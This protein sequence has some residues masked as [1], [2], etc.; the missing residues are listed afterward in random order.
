MVTQAYLEDA[1]E[2][3]LDGI[4][5]DFPEIPAVGTPIIWK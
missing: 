4:E 2:E 3:A 1:I 5:P